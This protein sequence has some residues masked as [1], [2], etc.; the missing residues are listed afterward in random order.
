MSSKRG[1]IFRNTW[2]ESSG[3]PNERYQYRT[4]VTTRAGEPI[5]R[6]EIRL[7]AADYIYG[8]PPTIEEMWDDYLQRLAQDLAL[9]EITSG[10]RRDLRCILGPGGRCHYISAM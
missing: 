3:R 4:T 9:E 6:V 5:F 1:Y 10:E 8:A 7:W 2:V